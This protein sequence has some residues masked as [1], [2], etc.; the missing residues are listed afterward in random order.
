MA[1]A[2]PVRFSRPAGQ[3]LKLGAFV[4]SNGP[5][6]KFVCTFSPFGPSA[7]LSAVAGSASPVGTG[8]TESLIPYLVAYSLV[9]VRIRR[10]EVNPLGTPVHDAWAGD[11]SA[12]ELHPYSARIATTGSTLIARC[13]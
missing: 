11:P 9:K 1:A 5:N 12:I 13:A 6:V 8:L 2:Y 7:S 4:A 3:R 10:Q